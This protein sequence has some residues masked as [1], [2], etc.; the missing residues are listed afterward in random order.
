MTARMIEILT[1]TPD[2]RYFFA[3]GVAHFFGDGSVN[4]LLEENGF[5]VQRLWEILQ[6]GHLETDFVLCD[7]SY[8][9]VPFSSKY[10]YSIFVYL[11]MF[12][13]H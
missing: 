5:T 7:W 10:I 11:F 4:E 8:N 6:I 12:N 2:A 13:I 9:N 1:G 3:F